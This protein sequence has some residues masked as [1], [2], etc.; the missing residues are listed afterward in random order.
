MPERMAAQKDAKVKVLLEKIAAANNEQSLRCF[1]VEAVQELYPPCPEAELRL[2]EQALGRPLPPSYRNFLRHCNGWRGFN[3]GVCLLGTRYRQEKDLLAAIEEFQALE[4]LEGRF[5]AATGIFVAASP[6]GRYFLY[7]DIHTRHSNGEMELVEYIYPN[8]EVACYPDFGVYLEKHCERLADDAGN[9]FL[10]PS[11]SEE[12]RMVLVDAAQAQEMVAKRDHKILRELWQEKEW[13]RSSLLQ[14]MSMSVGPW[15]AEDRSL[16]FEFQAELLGEHGPVDLRGLAIAAF[17][18]YDLELFDKVAAKMGDNVAGLEFFAA[19]FFQRGKY[20]EALRVLM[21][22][23]ESPVASLQAW[24]QLVE[25]LGKV[26]IP[27]ADAAALLLRAEAKALSK[28]K[29]YQAVSVAWLQLKEKEKALKAAVNAVR[30]GVK[31]EELR[32]DEDF[33]PLHQDPEFNRLFLE[34][35]QRESVS[36]K[37][38]KRV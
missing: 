10:L 32:R 34:A 22:V 33:A 35:Y 15:S 17:L 23:I 1:G 30:G 16:L 19:D 20:A 11:M 2:Y 14:S 29:L 36:L 3:R 9:Q 37:L 26:E 12:M 28:P 13:V 27:Y 21:A 31:L 4:A 18:E 38:N 5:G 8:G 7:Y 25:A 6:D 24:M